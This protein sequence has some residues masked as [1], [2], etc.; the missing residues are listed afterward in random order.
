[1]AEKNAP[2]CIWACM[3]GP[4][5]GLFVSGNNTLD[6]PEYIRADIADKLAETYLSRARRLKQEMTS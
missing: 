4:M 1:M 2:E 3:E 6:W 5:I